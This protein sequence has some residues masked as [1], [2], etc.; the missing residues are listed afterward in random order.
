MTKL[1]SKE[2]QKEIENY[3]VIFTLLLYFFRTAIPYLKFP[4]LL[5]YSLTI[6]YLIINYNN[7]IFPVIVKFVRTYYIIL[8]L[9]GILI[10]SFFLS[11][12]LYLSIFKDVIN[13][14]ILLSFF[15]IMTLIVDWK[16][17]LDKFVNSFT[18]SIILFALGISLYRLIDLFNIF[19]NDNAGYLYQIPYTIEVGSIQ[20][21]YNFAILPIFFGIITVIYY[22][23]KTDS[24]FRKLVYSLLLTIY[25]ITIFFA[26]SRRGMIV[27]IGITFLLS[28]SQFFTFTKR[29]SFFKRLGLGSRF[30][31]LFLVLLAMSSWFFVF[32]TSYVFKNKT[33]ELLGTKNLVKTKG[34]I[35]M[36]VAR[37]Y[38]VIDQT[39]SFSDL[40]NVIW[41][42]VFNPDDPDSGWGSRMH[43]TVFPLSG[44]NVEIVP[45]NAK[46]YFMDHNTNADT[47]NK[48]AY[49]ATWISNHNVDEKDILNASV[50][51]YVSKD[52]DLSM[53]EICSMG[54]MGNPGA[55][56]DFHH[57]GKWQRLNFSVK[58]TK[59]YAGVLLFFSKSNVNDF[60]SVNGYVIFAYPQVKILDI[61]NGALFN[62]GNIHEIDNF[63]NRGNKFEKNNSSF[64][65]TNHVFEA[66]ITDFN[67]TYSF[68]LASQKGDKDPIRRWTSRFISED[69]T[70]YSYK[71][72]LFVDTISNQLLQG[73]LARWEFAFQIFTKEY[74][75]KQKVFGGGF[76]Y[77]N[78][79]GYFF[80]KDKKISDY[81]HNPFLSVLLYSGVIGLL[82][83]LFFIFK[84]FYYYISYFKE[85]YLMSIFFLITFFFSFFSAGSPFDPPI[86][87]FF[88]ILPFFM[89]Q[90]INN[91][92]IV[93]NH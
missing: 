56:Y 74:N 50:F 22:L 72:K 4:F 25:S 40:Y 38:L 86:M 88:V 65:R 92:E 17:D 87:G 29:Q 18:N 34:E 26:G 81:P 32:H 42:P 11:K 27:L 59:G 9:V 93:K 24:F 55:L 5:L 47:L 64:Q 1:F 83:Y 20:V 21:D 53:V 75:W 8:I 19:Q 49:S 69:T 46:G 62:T 77:L 35:A 16:S 73:R 84:A 68:Q 30:F 51:C 76:N 57:K 2:S 10:I 33:L 3:A 41:T 70:Y 82:I 14:I 52:C 6:I 13:S 85:Y 7:K 44:D 91:D 39:K 48:N 63:K 80:L 43:K 61:N 71:Q 31:L 60:S 67:W 78:W 12:K 66:G 90:I 89:H 45:A 28:I 15:L 23:M 79:F 54:A 37:Y 36:T 58:C